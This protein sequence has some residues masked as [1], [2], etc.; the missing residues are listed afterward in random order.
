MG[1][2]SESGN[3]AFY[4]VFSVKDLVKTIIPHFLKYPLLT[5]KGADFMLFKQIVDLMD[6]KAHLTIKG[7]NHIINIKAA[8]NLGLS[9]LLKSEFKY[10]N[11][12]AGCPW[13][14][15]PLILTETIPDPYWIT[16]FVDGEGTF[17]IKIYSSK[18]NVGFAVQL[19]FRIPQHER[20]T[21]L[22][23]LLMK[24]FNSGSIE[25]HT[26]YPAVTLVINKFTAITEIII[27]FFE[28]YPL[29]G[30]KK[31]DYLDWYSV[32]RLM[33]NKAHLTQDGLNLIRTIKSGMNTGRK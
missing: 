13:V 14:A 17:D 12:G 27:P 33:S 11:L 24:Y 7:I 23:E 32:A 25:K 20:D 16:G 1:S 9:E 6:N 21:K 19:R 31:N 4:S 28:S 10:I 8:M 29:E 30:V 2:V 15:R 5:Q 3:M 18:T 22:I 26:K